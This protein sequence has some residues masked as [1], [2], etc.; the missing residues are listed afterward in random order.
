VTELA[1]ILTVAAIEII[2]PRIAANL[3]AKLLGCDE[4]VLSPVVR[5]GQIRIHFHHGYGTAIA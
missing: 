5:L 3:G 4:H 2:L 1:G